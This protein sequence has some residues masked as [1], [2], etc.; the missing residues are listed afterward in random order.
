M[1][2]KIK[3][4]EEIEEDID[5]MTDMEEDVEEVEVKSKTVSKDGYVC[6]MVAF[7]KVITEN[8]SMLCAKRMKLL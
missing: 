8:R 3:D 2:H 5:Y 4:R 7:L 1:V 6:S